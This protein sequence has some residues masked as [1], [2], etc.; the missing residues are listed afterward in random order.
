MPADMRILGRSATCAGCREL[1]QTC[2]E[3][4][5]VAVAGHSGFR[6]RDL[7]REGVVRM[8]HEPT[9]PLE[10]EVPRDADDDRVLL[11]HIVAGIVGRQLRASSESPSLQY[12]KNSKPPRPLSKI[13]A[14]PQPALPWSSLPSV[15]K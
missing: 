13:M 9:R 12:A 7:R 10:P 14:I 4:R 1:V 11:C 8:N 2:Q 3:V 6:G 5:R 15:Y